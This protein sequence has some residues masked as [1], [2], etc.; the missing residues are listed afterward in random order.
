MRIINK[1]LSKI[2]LINC[3]FGLSSSFVIAESDWR[4]FNTSTATNH[5]LPAYKQLALTTTSMSRKT[6]AFCESPTPKALVEVK[7]EFASALNAWQ[8]IQHINFG[9]VETLSRHA[10]ME[11]WPDKK[12]H[13]NKHLTKL[14]ATKNDDKLIPGNFVQNSIAIRGFP[15]IELLIYNKDALRQLSDDTFRCQVL[16]AISEHVS[17][18]SQA[19]EKEWAAMLSQFSDPTQVD[20]FFEDD[21]DAATALLRTL[22][23]PLEVIEDLKLKRALGSNVSFAK[24]KRLESWRSAQTLNN[25]KT[26][27]ASLQSLYSGDS[28]SNQTNGL[29]ALLSKKQDLAIKAQFAEVNRDLSKLPSPL[30]E[31][32]NKAETYA[33]LNG[34]RESIQLLRE[35]IEK[36]IAS[37]GIN[38]GFNSRDGD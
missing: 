36:S 1:R 31:H 10:A 12:N 13:V 30:T 27:L 5:V 3:L 16:I 17:L 15:A 20:G 18:T 2:L 7:Q 14:V 38:L 23:E 34:V 32:I 11:F 37:L 6:G 26:N 25:L 8:A 19:L 28:A 24:P 9:P 35:S 21:I 29:S 4:S 22:V 33:A